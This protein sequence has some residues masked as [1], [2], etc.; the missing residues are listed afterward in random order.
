MIA[1]ADATEMVNLYRDATDG[2]GC[3][4]AEWRPMTMHSVTREPYLHHEWDE[5]YDH[6][7]VP[8]RLQDLAR[9]ISGVPEA[10]EMQARVAKI[11]ADRAEMAEGERPFDWGRGKS[12]LCYAGG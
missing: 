8:Q 7:V 4:V 5:P 9:R 1:L 12:G 10:V 11:Y 3:V 6:A 2:G